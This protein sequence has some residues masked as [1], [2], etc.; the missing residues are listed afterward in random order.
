MT[1]SKGFGFWADLARVDT[2]VEGAVAPVVPLYEP[3]L[4]DFDPYEFSYW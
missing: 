1:G 4:R 3:W 2:V